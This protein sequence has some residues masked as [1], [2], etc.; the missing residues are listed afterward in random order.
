LLFAAGLGYGMYKLYQWEPQTD[1]QGALR[2]LGLIAGGAYLVH[3]AL[4]FTTKRSLP[5]VGRL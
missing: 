5:L 3:L 4:D 2:V 1:L